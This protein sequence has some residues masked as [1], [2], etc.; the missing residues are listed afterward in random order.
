MA[1]ITF[2]PEEVFIFLKENNL[3]P[4]PLNRMISSVK[5][6]KGSIIVTLRPF[7]YLKKTIAVEMIYQEFIDEKIV[8]KIKTNSLFDKVLPLFSKSFEDESVSIRKSMLSID[9]QKIIGKHF[10]VFTI[11]D[12]HQVGADFE[13]TTRHI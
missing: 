11:V 1:K 5:T 4:S 7:S 9:T 10:N 13:I 2:H 6:Q 3:L 8:F 12:M